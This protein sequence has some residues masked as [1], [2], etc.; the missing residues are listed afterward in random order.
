MPN[1]HFAGALSTGI[2]VLLPLP[3]HHNNEGEC[4]Q[5]TPDAYRPEECMPIGFGMGADDPGWR[6][7]RHSYKKDPHVIWHTPIPTIFA[8]DQTPEG[9]MD[10]PLIVKRIAI[11]EVDSKMD[12]AEHLEVQRYGG[13]FDRRGRVSLGLTGGVEDVAY[14]AIWNVPEHP[15]LRLALD[16]G[17]ERLIER[18]IKHVI[19]ESTIPDEGRPKEPALVSHLRRLREEG[20][21]GI[22]RMQGLLEEDEMELAIEYIHVT[23]GRQHPGW[24]SNSLFRMWRERHGVAMRWKFGTIWIDVSRRT[25]ILRCHCTNA[26]WCLSIMAPGMEWFIWHQARSRLRAAS[27]KAQNADTAERGWHPRPK[28]GPLVRRQSGGADLRQIGQAD[29]F[30]GCP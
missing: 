1:V 25:A 14:R 3:D 30:A 28:V 15:Q 23:T 29:A 16:Y 17:L 5:Y 19:S 22:R 18:D 6:V 24:I 10:L 26:S 11:D 4:N 21:D 7:A 2:R 13:N 20:S 9:L 8:I 27:S 12:Y